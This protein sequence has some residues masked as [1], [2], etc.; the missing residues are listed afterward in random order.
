MKIRGY[1][2]EL[3]EVEAALSNLEEVRETTVVAREGLDGTKQ[4]YA[5]YVGEPS[6]SAG[7]F[8]EILSRELPD[9]MIPSYFIHLERIPLTSNGKIDLKALPVAD[10]KRGWKMNT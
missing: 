5:Y 10:E 8:R 4:L 9:Y 6:L 2:I 3:G 7:Q 1:R